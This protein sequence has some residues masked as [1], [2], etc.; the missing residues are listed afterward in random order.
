MYTDQ[1]FQA[2]KKKLFA[3]VTVA[4]LILLITAA[5]V[6]ICDSL[7]VRS[8]P[9]AVAAA[10][11]GACVLYAYVSVKCAPW[12]RYQRYL[13]D[14]RNGLSHETS[15]QFV[16]VS[17]GV[18]MSDGVMFHEFILQ[19]GEDG[20]DQRLFL[21]DDDFPRPPLAQGQRITL[22]S[23]GNYIIELSGT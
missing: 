8:W 21:W 17:D 11:V 18:R 10:V 3:R 23:F 2:V 4:A 15:G 1:Y 16:S 9:G 14:M 6:G 20:E 5:L 7:A 22:R 13:V 19:V 12:Y